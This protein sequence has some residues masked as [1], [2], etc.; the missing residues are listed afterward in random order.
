VRTARGSR[1]SQSSRQDALTRVRDARLLKDGLAAR[2]DHR[3]SGGSI[4]SWAWRRRSEL[5]I[6]ETE[7]ALIAAL[8]I[9]GSSSSPKNG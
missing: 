2:G 4:H 8:A 1:S 7:L 3:Q 9:I 5:T 6:T